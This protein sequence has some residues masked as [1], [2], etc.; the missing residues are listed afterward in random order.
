VAHITGGSF[1]KL[2]R[3]NT[4]VTYELEELPEPTGIFKQIQADGRIEM[5]EMYRTFNMGI[6]LC[7]VCPKSASDGIVRIFKKFGMRCSTVGRIGKGRGEVFARI[8][9]KRQML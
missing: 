7:I 2:A 4:R 6:G 3:L 1:T 8:S 9:G 5:K